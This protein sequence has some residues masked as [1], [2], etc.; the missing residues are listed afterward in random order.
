VVGPKGRHNPDRI[1]VRHGRET[2]EVTLGG[3]R[4]RIERP[5]VRTADGE[6]EVP[7]ESYR[8]FAERDPPT[9][10]VLE[11]M[12]PTSPRGAWSARASRSAARS[13][14]RRSTSKSAVGREFVARTC[15]NLDALM[16]RRLDDVSPVSLLALVSGWLGARA[17]KAAPSRLSHGERRLAVAKGALMG[18]VA[19]S[20][21][22]TAIQ[23]IRFSGQAPGGAFRS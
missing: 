4:V 18:A 14:R 20:G 21:I 7:L 10:V 12:L 1:A 11:Q 3:R 6:S 5:R 16:S 8:H 23:G 19:V 2:G 15:E 9:R 17:E 22:A 13:S